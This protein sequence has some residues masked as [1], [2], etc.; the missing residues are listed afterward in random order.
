MCNG[1]GEKMTDQ[2]EIDSNDSDW[3]DCYNCTHYMIILTW[4]I[5]G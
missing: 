3:S 5:T 1:M 2:T 4:L